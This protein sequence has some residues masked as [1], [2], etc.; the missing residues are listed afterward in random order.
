MNLAQ[1]MGLLCVLIIGV[2]TSTYGAQDN[3]MP[4]KPRVDADAEKDGD[5]DGAHDDLSAFYY[6]THMAMA[7]SL[8]AKMEQENRGQTIRQANKALLEAVCS[9]DA[10]EITAILASLTPELR[11][12]VIFITQ[13]QTDWTV[14]FYA[15]AHGNAQVMIALLAPFTREQQF[16]IIYNVH[17]SGNTA[18]INAA[19]SDDPGALGVL[20]GYAGL[21]NLS[22]DEL[23]ELGETLAEKDPE[24]LAQTRRIITDAL[25]SYARS[26]R[27][28]ALRAWAAA[29]RRSHKVPQTAA[30]SAIEATAG[31]ADARLVSGSKRRNPHAAET[32]VAKTEDSE[33]RASSMGAG[34]G[35]SASSSAASPAK[36]PRPDGTRDDA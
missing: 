31:S 4:P 25:R 26:R 5:R 30:S 28:P 23:L 20:I 36:R 29:R 17:R 8:Y 11:W 2:G 32:N 18:H 12:T 16:E 19:S 1:K 24:P 21:N 9:G 35:A 7:S 34:A 15:A 14:V 33:T 6:E 3:G 22:D 13:Y 10:E 27:D